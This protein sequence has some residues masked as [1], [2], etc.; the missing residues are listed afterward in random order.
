MLL[1][2][3]ASL[4]LDLLGALRELPAISRA[5][6]R[7]AEHTEVLPEVAAATRTLP[8]LE[9]EM[10]R[11][12]EATEL[13]A[14]MDTRMAAIA[15][16]MPVLIEVQRHLAQ[17]PETIERLDGRITELS[18]LLGGLQESLEPLGRI[19]RRLPGQRDHH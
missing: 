10:T 5:T 9:R 17:L 1:G 19:A 18:A 8:E 4:P 2:R 13:I 3:V 15:D 11:V 7:M 6:Q 12:A 14:V 16:A